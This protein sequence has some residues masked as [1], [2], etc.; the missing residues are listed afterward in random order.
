MALRS[1]AVVPPVR[2]WRSAHGDA[3][4]GGAV[5]VPEPCAD[6]VRPIPPGV[7]A[8]VERREDGTVTPAGAAELARRRHELSKL[9]DFGD[10]AAPWLP[11]AAELAPFD[12]ARRDLL[13]QRRDEICTLTGGVDS[14]VGAQLRAWAYIHAAGEY[15]ASKFFAS[16]DQSAFESMV[17]AFKASST[18][19]AK[20]RD[21][22]A[23]AAKARPKTTKPIWQ[24]LAEAPPADASTSHVEPPEGDS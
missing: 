7:A 4:K 6:G 16:G 21:A 3:A 14:G 23:W 8:P 15:W 22:A 13:A 20:L 17:R 19:D 5:K 24:Q 11:P 10:K 1:D 12:A 2:V 18:E 9:P